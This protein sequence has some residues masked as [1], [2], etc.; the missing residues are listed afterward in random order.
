MLKKFLIFSLSLLTFAVYVQ[1]QEETPILN[2]VV[3]EEKER[4]DVSISTPEAFQALSELDMQCSDFCGGFPYY[5]ILENDIS[6]NESELDSTCNVN[7]SPIDYFTGTL[8]GNGHSISGLCLKDT[9]LVEV[10]ENPAIFKTV[11]N[12]V[13]K[14]LSLKNIVSYSASWSS[15]VLALYAQN[16]L[17]AE[18]ITFEDI[19]LITKEMAFYGLIAG[20]LYN[21]S[22]EDTLHLVF[23]NIKGTN[24]HFITGNGTV[25]GLIGSISNNIKTEITNSSLDLQ[26]TQLP[27][28]E[29]FQTASLTFGGFIG[30]GN[31]TYFSNDTLNL[32]V[33]LLN[34]NLATESFY[35]G[36]LIGSASNKLS[37]ENVVIGGAVN[38]T[39]E[40]SIDNY[41]T[42]GSIFMGGLVGNVN[43]EDTVK[44]HNTNIDLDFNLEYSSAM[45]INMGSIA[46]YAYAGLLDFY[47]V[48]YTGEMSIT[49]LISNNA[50]MVGGFVGESYSPATTGLSS[51]SVSS[52][53]DLNMDG[54]ID[55]SLIEEGTAPFEVFVGGFLGKA[56]FPS[57]SS[58][59]I[60]FLN[61][62][63]NGEIQIDIPNTFLYFGGLA[64]YLDAL[65]TPELTIEKINISSPISLAS[66]HGNVGGLF[67]YVS[68]ITSQYTSNIVSSEINFTSATDFSITLE[69]NMFLN[70]GG[71]VGYEN[72][73]T[74]NFISNEVSANIDVDYSV[75]N[76]DNPD[77]IIQYEDCAFGGFIGKS[78]YSASTGYEQF[79]ISQSEF[80]GKIQI[81]NSIPTSYIGGLVGLNTN[82]TLNINSSYAKNTTDTLISVSKNTN[83]SL[84]INT[85]IVGGLVGTILNET[86]RVYINK[87]FAEG[88][89]RNNNEI[90]G[91]ITDIVSGLIGNTNG[92]INI[93]NAYFV[94]NIVLDN[95][96]YSDAYGLFYSNNGSENDY[97]SFGY[98]VDYSSN[99]RSLTNQE[100]VVLEVVA[101]ANSADSLVYIN[102]STIDSLELGTPAFAAQ[103]NKTDDVWYHEPNTKDG[104]PQFVYTNTS[105]VKPTYAVYLYEKISSSSVED[106]SITSSSFKLMDYYTNE[107]G[108]LSY[109]R[110]GSLI[111]FKTLPP[112]ILF[113]EQDSTTF[114]FHKNME[115]IESDTIIDYKTW[116]NDSNRIYEKSTSF[117]ETTVKVTFGGYNQEG[118][119][120]R[121]D[122]VPDI[123]IDGSVTNFIASESI[124]SVLRQEED[125][126][127]RLYS[128]WETSAYPYGTCSSTEDLWDI[129]H[130]VSNPDYNGVTEIQMTL[131]TSLSELFQHTLN[132]EYINGIE[133]EAELFGNTSN[134]NISFETDFGNAIIPRVS[135]MVVSKAYGMPEK[136]ISDSII[137]SIGDTAIYEL[138]L[139]DTINLPTHNASITLYPK[140]NYNINMVIPDLASPLFQTNDF[141]KTYQ[142]RQNEVLLP[143]IGTLNACLENYVYNG[144]PL[145][146]YERENQYSMT[147]SDTGDVYIYAE[148]N[149]ACS[150][151]TAYIT[152]KTDSGIVTTISH[153]GQ[154][155]TFNKNNE[156][157]FPTIGKL[158]FDIQNTPIAEEFVLDSL[159]LNGVRLENDSLFYAE[160][161]VDLQVFLR[162]LED[163]FKIQKAILAM[164]GSALRWTITPEEIKSYHPMRLMVTLFNADSSVVLDTI[165]S[166]NAESGKEY[167]MEYWPLPPGKYYALAELSTN[168]YQATDSVSL[169]VS[170]NLNDFVS[171]ESWTMVSL[172]NLDTSK[173][174]PEN[175]E[176]VTLYY[177][178][179]KMPVGEYWQY[180]R[181]EKAADIAPKTGYWFFAE[182]ST[183]LPMS[184]NLLKPEKDSIS[185]D[186][187]NNYSGWNL[188]SNPYS[189]DID[190]NHGSAFLDAENA[191]EP[192]WIWNPKLN[193]YEPANTLK[194]NSAF[195]IHT[196][197]SR[198]LTTSNRPVYAPLDTLE[199]LSK[200]SAIPFSKTSWSLRLKLMDET[201]KYGDTWNVVGV[202][203]RALSIEKPPVGMTQSFTL[204]TQGD[205]RT[206]A[207][208][209]KQVG[210][211]LTWVLNLQANGL[212]TALLKLEGMNKLLENGYYAELLMDGKRIVINSEEGIKLNLSSTPKQALLRVVPKASI[213]S[214]GKI[215]NL[216][217]TRNGSML[218]LSF[219]RNVSD[220]GMATL[221]LI[222]SQGRIVS[223]THKKTTLGE[224]SLSLDVPSAKGSF[225]L[226]LLV[227]NDSKTL[228]MNF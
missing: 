120:V 185:W 227:G 99:A 39:E 157:L 36:G 61:S 16:S 174:K 210:D 71:L 59:G 175:D 142:Y 83:E 188:L 201:E 181:L 19:T 183:V 159:T 179:E 43:T 115:Y 44:V 132:F 228:P 90:T 125:G 119:Y 215:Q 100:I 137:L 114:S 144:E 204:S 166:E 121:I 168:N 184:N 103:L 73:G 138:A 158:R 153:Y 75:D 84:P 212:K 41:M 122:S 87:S 208:S 224:N 69:T 154:E 12:V 77:A 80:T 34:S 155:L 45:Q 145:Y 211:S 47:Q 5:V 3:N 135:Q 127:Y 17:N 205:H 156:I 203:S 98:A 167:A 108:K 176:D 134:Y 15:A 94:G 74:K 104:L 57:G 68:A 170:G 202:G 207:K 14:N 92:N 169:E 152:L 102:N 143:N 150:V 219:N 161:D 149:S 86:D 38:S 217:Y 198:T 8:D 50:L 126:N 171:Q 133:Y 96:E 40:A 110:D 91:D 48:N 195:F 105:G 113:D 64:G 30:S 182:D 35:F 173:W 214:P 7:F 29:V 117:Y 79:Q 26:V 13:F 116:E 147:P 1:G 58:Y 139:G 85:T 178:N 25:G 70:I 11:D 67:G 206:L 216:R 163:L 60:N 220:N 193:S 65:G 196:E 213:V 190:L 42:Q 21:Y 31:I 192:A 4:C 112:S 111:D 123:L 9:L 199:V 140:I 66:Y 197:E 222:D 101:M 186:L 56:D 46:A 2:C 129:I 82:S 33:S 194:A 141:P 81:E 6:F 51:A 109:Q 22:E 151:D 88:I 177:W 95:P 164:S 97:I 76:E 165:L 180:H 89:L 37:V 162:E 20:E 52:Y 18:N 124:P 200:S 23:D 225:F 148:M 118:L 130:Y 10:A 128:Y 54:S 221:R 187:E 136:A 146:Y 53:D 189:W 106:P 218:Q 72:S 27:S 226:N 24:I 55:V 107:I 28:S 131:F 223:F 191:E 93:R 62:E 78:D 209:I 32:D 160:S 63:I 172:A 49:D